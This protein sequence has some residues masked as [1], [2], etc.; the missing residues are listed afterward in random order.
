M[1]K[2]LMSSKTNHKSTDM[3]KTKL[4]TWLAL[5]L[6]IS[7]CATTAQF[8]VSSVTPAADILVKMKQDKNGN[9][10]VLITAKNLASAERLDPPKK[11]YI[12]WTNTKKDGIR[13]LGKLNIQNAKTNA[14]KTVTPFKCREIFITAE[15]REEVTYPS[16]VEISRVRFK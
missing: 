4:I 14:L 2:N 3:K 13:N 16:G 6:F 7:S 12:V 5:A 9:Y 15:D 11:V 10:I 1:L 8:P